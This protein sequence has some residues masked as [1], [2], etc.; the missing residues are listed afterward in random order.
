MSYLGEEVEETP[1]GNITAQVTTDVIG[2][3]QTN[4]EYDDMNL[5]K[6][7]INVNAV[8]EEN[9]EIADGGN[10]ENRQGSCSNNSNGHG[11]GHSSVVSALANKIYSKSPQNDYS[12]QRLATELTSNPTAFPLRVDY[13][14][15]S[16][17]YYC[18]FCLAPFKSFIDCTIHLDQHCYCA[19]CEL[20]FIS[21]VR[22]KQHLLSSHDRVG[23]YYCQIC[24]KDFLFAEMN[25]L[26]THVAVSHATTENI[27]INCSK[28]PQRFS[29]IGD[30]G[31]HFNSAHRDKSF[32]FS[33]SANT[34]SPMRVIT[35]PRHTTNSQPAGATVSSVTN[36]NYNHPSQTSTSFPQSSLAYIQQ[37]GYNS[38]SRYPSTTPQQA[39]NNSPNGIWPK[40]EYC[41]ICRESFA[42]PPALLRHNI[43]AHNY[44]QTG[45]QINY[46]PS[47][48]MQYQPQ[49]QGYQAQGSGQSNAGSNM[50]Y[51]V[52]EFCLTSICQEKLD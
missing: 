15:D 22:F 3:V 43:Y 31:I 38:G 49:S 21:I 42:S 10:C 33:M 7:S 12:F 32:Q 44:S 9:N 5:P 6:I 13:N 23:K 27:N 17:D 16:G 18:Q 28:C 4:N 36:P 34:S 14:S 11:H 20:Q 39:F 26:F 37:S 2:S 8:L 45:Q 1:V 48:K 50:F 35:L 30:L 40:K 41:L 29:T 51:T 25:Q 52:G 24:S 46:A 19:T 47:N